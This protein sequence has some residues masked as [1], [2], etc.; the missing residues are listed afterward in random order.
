[1]VF[2]DY[3]PE[4]NEFFLYETLQFDP[5]HSRNHFHL[6]LQTSLKK[7]TFFGG[8]GSVPSD[9]F[10]SFGDTALSQ[11]MKNIKSKFLIDL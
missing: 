10:F 5:R 2:W 1:M 11:N 3:T 6:K 4:G 8:R 7:M 9:I